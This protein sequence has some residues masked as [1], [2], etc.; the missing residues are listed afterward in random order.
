MPWLYLNMFCPDKKL[1]VKTARVEMEQPKQS[2]V[3]GSRGS[4]GLMVE[5]NMWYSAMNISSCF[6]I[7][8]FEKQAYQAS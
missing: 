3:F 8:I 6:L 1:Y 7:K 2:S 5:M 4:G